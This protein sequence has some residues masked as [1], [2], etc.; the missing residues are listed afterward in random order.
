MKLKVRPIFSF[1]L[2][3][4]A[5]VLFNTY[6]AHAE[7]VRKPVWA[8]RFYPSEFSGLSAVISQLTAKAQKTRLQLPQNKDLKA[9]VMPHAGYIYLGWTAAHVSMVLHANQFSKVILLGPDHSIGLGNGAICDASAY[10]TPLGKVNLHKDTIQLRRQHDLFQ[11][12]PV[13]LDREHSLEV[14]LPFLQTYLE[15]FQLIPVILGKG[16]LDAFPMPWIPF[17]AM[18]PC[19]WSAPIFHTFL[20][21]LQRLTVTVKLLL[22]S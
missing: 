15:K 10:E 22:K 7:P 1:C 12:L 13:S 4:G 5:V 6:G 14:I 18:A 19:S 21:I 11:T 3:L 17:W 20:H 8:G 9:I 16:I 2:A